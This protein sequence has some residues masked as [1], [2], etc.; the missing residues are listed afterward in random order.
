MCDTFMRVNENVRQVRQQWRLACFSVFASA[1]VV[2]CLSVQV[3]LSNK[4]CMNMEL[5]VN[6]IKT[7]NFFIYMC[8]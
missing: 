5:N 8:G 4:I 1:Q 3:R 7:I 6:S 2:F